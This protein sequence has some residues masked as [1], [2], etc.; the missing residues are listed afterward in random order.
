[1]K[2]R[3]DRVYM[4]SLRMTKIHRCFGRLVQC[5]PLLEAVDSVRLFNKGLA[6]EFDIGWT[7]DPWGTPVRSEEDLGELSGSMM[8]FRFRGAIY[9]KESYVRLQGYKIT[10]SHTTHWGHITLACTWNC[11][12]V[13]VDCSSDCYTSTFL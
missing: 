5:R 4:C 1:M 12:S 7:P 10:C 2:L 8:S 9:V 11:T 3:H 6:F 13:T